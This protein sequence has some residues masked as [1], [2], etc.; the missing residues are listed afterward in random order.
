MPVRT[1]YADLEREPLTVR[2]PSRTPVRHSTVAGNTHQTRLTTLQRTAGNR[3]LVRLAGLTRDDAPSD[4]TATMLRRS[5]DPDEP[6]EQTEDNGTPELADLEAASP[7]LHTDQSAEMLGLIGDLNDYLGLG[8]DLADIAGASFL[9]SAAVTAAAGVVSL[10][11]Q[12]FFILQ[13]I[14]LWISAWGESDRKVALLGS[15]AGIVATAR[16]EEAPQPPQGRWLGTP[17]DR[18]RWN[19]VWWRNTRSGRQWVH[20]SLDLLR[21]T[22][23][24]LRCHGALGEM[25]AALAPHLTGEFRGDFERNLPPVLALLLKARESPAETLNALYQPLA[26]EHLAPGADRERY[27]WPP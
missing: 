8:L 10:L 7:E 21:Y 25:L 26:R 16:G 23:R 11:G 17:Q 24:Q 4:T 5:S 15:C 9:E 2:T 27:T 6:E 20:D 13:A 12:A 14:G 1:R 19:D 18:D 22:Q 3:V